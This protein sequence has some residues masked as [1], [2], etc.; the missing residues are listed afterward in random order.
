MMQFDLPKELSSIIKVIG[1]GGG[2]SNAVNHMFR[3]GIKGVDFIVCNTDKQALD[4]SPV[5]VKVQLGKT[6][7][8]GL[9]AGMLPEVGKNAAI[10]SIEEI[11]GLLKGTKMVFITAGM[12]KGT[13]T[14][15]AP[16]IAQAAKEMGILTVGIVTIPFSF[17][18]A[19]KRAQA[20]AGIEELKK[21]IDTLLIICNERLRE[22]HGNLTVVNAFTH[23][24]NVL[25]GAAR[26]IAEIISNTLHVNVDFN[27]IQTVMKE[28]GV[29]IMGTA[30]ASGDGRAINAVEM[31]LNSPLLNDSEIIGA[32]YVLMNVTSGADEITMD[33]LSEITDY[34]QNA[35]GQTAEIVTGYGVDPNLGDKVSVTIIATGFKS[36]SLE[37]FEAKKRSDKKVLKLDDN[38]N[39]TVVPIVEEKKEEEVSAVKEEN[40]EPVLKSSITEKEEE[41]TVDSFKEEVTFSDL[42]SDPLEP[43]LI[44]KE[45]VVNVIEVPEVDDNEE[46]VID[47]EPVAKVE[48]VITPVADLS[49]EAVAK[50]EVKVEEVIAPVAE[51]KVEEV[52]AVADIVVEEVAPIVE[53]VAEINPDSYREEEVVEPVAEVKVE[54][55]VAPVVEPVAEVKVEEVITPVIEPVAE[56]KVEEVT[57]ELNSDISFEFEKAPE[58]VIEFTPVEETVAETKVEETIQVIE[59]VAEVK[60]EE[61]TPVVE[62]VAETKIE[63]VIAPVIEPVAE[64]KV[65]EVIA[66]VVEPVAEVKLEEVTEEPMLI[67]NRK[68]IVEEKKVETTVPI[69]QTVTDE[70]QR[71]KAQERILRL[72]ELSLKLKSPN[73]LAE[74]ENEPAYKRKNINLENTPHS[75]ESQVSKYT[76]TENEEKKVEIKPNNSFLHDNV[77]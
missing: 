11:K 40:L 49:T 77:D 64:T 42:V 62:P 52:I 44:I 65:E 6:L 30:S 50:V 2:G 45:P 31:A 47:D 43:T 36:K 5:P 37:S 14:G 41:L 13:G 73:G 32:R 24:D 9:G 48:E 19:K 20:E 71:R 55:I 57:S 16:I 63:E 54:E 68:E 59:P 15:A 53:P 61:V 21:H 8:Q 28:S 39:K 7:T 70:E 18:G 1:V 25:S 22:I 33:E 35:A 51:T 29:A 26:S 17:E 66:P 75:S 10:E 69:S 34:I 74:L 3:Q 23:A 38:V 12:G 72:K 58:S 46:T 27:D 56:T 76:L 60:V 67:K 4:I